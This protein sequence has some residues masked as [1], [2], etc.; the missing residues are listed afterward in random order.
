MIDEDDTCRRSLL[1]EKSSTTTVSSW[2]TGNWST[3]SWTTGSW[4]TGSLRTSTLLILVLPEKRYRVPVP[5]PVPKEGDRSVCTMVKDLLSRTVVTALFVASCLVLGTTAMP[6]ETDSHPE[7]FGNLDGLGSGETAH[8]Q[9]SITRASRDEQQVTRQ[10]FTGESD[11][12]NK[13]DQ[14]RCGFNGDTL[15]SLISGGRIGRRSTDDKGQ[16]A[17]K[18]NTLLPGILEVEATNGTF[19]LKAFVSSKNGF[20]SCRTGR[21]ESIIRAI[22]DDPKVYCGTV[23]EREIQDLLQ[24]CA[25]KDPDAIF[26]QN[27]LPDLRASGNNQRQ[28]NKRGEKASFTTGSYLPFQPEKTGE[29]QGAGSHKTVM[30]GTLWCGT[31]N[32]AETYDDL[33]KFRQTDM[34]CREHDRCP[35]FIPK[36]TRKYKTFNKNPWTISHCD[37]DQQLF[38]CLKD[39]KSTASSIVGNVFFRI[40]GYKC[41]KFTQGEYCKEYKWAF[42]SCRSFVT[43]PMAVRIDS[44]YEW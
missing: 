7:R 32:N 44:P 28:L 4:T 20:I 36:L 26:Q 39:V 34:C 29:P 25:V 8:H 41:F 40:F 35:Y 15:S 5:V 3:G 22:I 24:R 2:T 33:G 27:S 43:G 31:G 30:T 38:Q 12:L 14:L 23:G 17:F 37:C 6:R 42:L 10:P 1:E 16:L 21:S 9:N 18:I 11:T 19:A 13:W